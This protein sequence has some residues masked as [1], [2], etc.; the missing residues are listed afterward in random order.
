[1]SFTSHISLPQN[2]RLEIPIAADRTKRHSPY[3]LIWFSTICL[4]LETN[5]SN[6]CTRTTTTCYESS[7][8]WGKIY[9][10]SWHD[11]ITCVV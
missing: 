6:I 9:S 3:C 10:L 4:P 8:I 7:A 11:D 5:V 2:S 1:M